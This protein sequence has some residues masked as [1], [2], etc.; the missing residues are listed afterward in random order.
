MQ[1]KAAWGNEDGLVQGIFGSKS[2]K[3]YSCQNEKGTDSGA[4]LCSSVP[5]GIELSDLY[6]LFPLILITTL[7]GRS[8]QET[9]AQSSYDLLS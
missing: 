6:S 8:Y 3:G 1:E 7:W 5:L 2:Q 4:K 9:E